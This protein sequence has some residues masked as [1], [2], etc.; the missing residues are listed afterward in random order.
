MCS[1]KIHIR[2]LCIYT[3]EDID[4]YIGGYLNI[5]Y[6]CFVEFIC[7]LV[8]L[9]KCNVGSVRWFDAHYTNRADGID[10][11]SSELLVEPVFHLVIIF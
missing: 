3:G 2:K 10:T 5:Y 1:I 11:F 6:F 8:K 7:V 4:M 9:L